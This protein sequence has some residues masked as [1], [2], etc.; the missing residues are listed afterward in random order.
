MSGIFD[1]E[2]PQRAT[3]FL[4][5]GKEQTKYK[6]T[7]PSLNR[8]FFQIAQVV[9]HELLHKK[10]HSRRKG[11]M[12]LRSI[13]V[14]YSRK[15]SK[16]RMDDVEYYSYFDEIESY[17]HDLAMEIKYYYPNVPPNTILNNIDKKRLLSVYQS[18]KKAFRGTEWGRVRKLL[19]KK[20]WK[21]LPTIRLPKMGVDN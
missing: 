19:L 14:I 18:Y 4:H 13:P 21:W 3:V 5:F 1:T 7:Q 2:R 9:H 6:L 17:S 12:Y 8:L 16:K 11:G 15:I 10:Q 20:T